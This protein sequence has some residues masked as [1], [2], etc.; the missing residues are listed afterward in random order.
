MADVRDVTWRFINVAPIMA[1]QSALD[2]LFAETLQP[3]GVDRFDCVRM[4][5]NSETEQ[6]GFLSNRGLADWNQYFFDQKY[7]E[8]DPCVAAT[9]TFHG[10]YT[11]TQVKA[12]VPDREADAVWS[13]ARA[14]GMREGLIVPVAPRR[15]SSPIVRL[16]TPEASIDP[17][18][19]PLLQ[20]ISAIYAVSVQTFTSRKP[21]APAE[22]TQNVSL[23]E[24]EVECL[25]WCARG[26][27]NPEIGTI[28][29]I[30]RHTVNSHVESAKRKLGVATRVQ[31]A[32]IA[33]QLGLMS[34]A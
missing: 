26:K 17:A 16:I 2:D 14:G 10:P 12:R 22:R 1:G 28:L 30:S 18:M 4:V 6:A 3:F 29:S 21:P 7:H 32:A 23:T 33:H 25:Y 11:W 8:N 15:L 9:E 24:R 20:S 19:I 34:I 13:D 31:A 5:A 27:S